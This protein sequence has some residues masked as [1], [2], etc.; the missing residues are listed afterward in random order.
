MIIKASAPSRISLFGGSTDL[1]EYYDTYGG[2]VISLAINLRTTISL[3]QGADSWGH[4]GTK[5]PQKANPDLYYSILT[6]QGLGGHHAATSQSSFDGVIGAGLGSSA[7][8]A[9][10]LLT[11]IKKANGEVINRREIAELA[12]EA[13]QKIGRTGGKQDQYAASYGGGNMILFYPNNKEI[14]IIGYERRVLDRLNNSLVLFYT[15]G[16][17]S[18][19]TFQK[20]LTTLT[21]GQLSSLA[22]IK[23][24]AFQAHKALLKGNIVTLGKLLHES[25]EA[26]KALNPNISSSKIDDIYTFA[27]KHG[28][29]GGKLCGAGGCGYM[30]FI[31]PDKRRKQ[32]VD[33]MQEKNLEETD[34]SISYEGLEGRIV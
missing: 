14:N 27:R 34:F 23:K 18:S 13:E 29:L 24:F 16:T 20:K 12:W 25:W 22:A 3:Y 4:P 17:R 26:K 5:F 2:V 30:V 8:F 1:P 10:A 21:E 6:S 9:V 15:G 11:A 28:A 33:K 19:S 32:F 31:V 7:S